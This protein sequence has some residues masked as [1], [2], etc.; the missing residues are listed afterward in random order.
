[1]ASDMINR[2]TKLE[3]HAQT[4]INYYTNYD[5]LTS[6][7]NNDDMIANTQILLRKYQFTLETLNIE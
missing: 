4:L 1:M 2:G 3:I 5:T 7:N 6:R